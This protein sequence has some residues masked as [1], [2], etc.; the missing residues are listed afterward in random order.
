MELSSRSKFRLTKSFFVINQEHY[1]EYIYGVRRNVLDLVHYG[2]TREELYFMP[3][4]EMLDYIEIM[5]DRAEHN[6]VVDPSPT[7][8][9]NLNDLKMMANTIPLA[10]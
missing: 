9:D 8:E 1:A 5:N 7:E 6:Q 10:Y 4:N 3:L 2:F